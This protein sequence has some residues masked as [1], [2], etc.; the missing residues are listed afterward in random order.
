M[1]ARVER[2]CSPA[3][4]FRRRASSW[5]TGFVSGPFSS[6]GSRKISYA[7]RSLDRC[8][9]LPLWLR[10]FEKTS[11]LVG[12]ASAR[13][14]PCRPSLI[15]HIRNLKVDSSILSG[16]RASFF[17]FLSLTQPP[18]AVTRVTRANTPMEGPWPERKATTAVVTWGAATD[19]PPAVEDIWPSS[20]FTF[21][22][23][24]LFPWSAPSA[25]TRLT[26]LRGLRS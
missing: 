1:A 4:R 6:H 13:V 26:R 2:S 19:D 3:I 21:V 25:E 24:C 5:T 14:T 15:M 23:R 17:C 11:P 12:R 22:A 10:C 9:Y 7:H 8:T 20:T 18:T 16:G